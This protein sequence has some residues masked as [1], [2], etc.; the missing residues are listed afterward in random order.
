MKKV[1]V[2]LLV[3]FFI[4]LIFGA[5]FYVKSE[6][7]YVK[8]L[9]PSVDNISSPVN[10]VAFSIYGKDDVV[11]YR[12][13]YMRSEAIPA[14][15]GMKNLMDILDIYLSEMYSS[16]SRDGIERWK[17]FILNRQGINP[18]SLEG[19]AFSYYT[20][21]LIK[22][23][24]LRGFR[25]EL[26]RWYTIDKLNK[27]YSKQGLTRILLNSPSFAENVYG[28][29]A[30]CRYYF[31][32]SIKE[33]TLLERAY[34]T[35]MLSPAGKQLD[36][37]DD[38]QEIDRTARNIV[39]RL[40]ENNKISLEEMQASMQERV[41]IEIDN[42]KMIE[43]SYV[44]AVLRQLSK[45]NVVS[46][47]LGKEDIAVYTGYNKRASDTARLVMDDYLK[48][49]DSKLQS[50]FVL[51]NK[52][53]QEVEVALG[54]RL[55]DTPVNRALTM[56]RQMASTFKPIVYLGAFEK[57]FR[58]S[59]QIVDKQYSFATKDYMYLPRNYGGRFMGKIPIRYGFI[60]SLNNATVRLGELAG[61]KYIRD[62]SVRLG[63]NNNVKPFYAMTL[64]AF[65]ATP[66]TVA[67]I[68]AG[69]GNGGKRV[70]P[71]LISRIRVGKK[72]Y[73]MVKKQNRVVSESSAYQAL[74]IM[75][76]VTKSGTGRHIGLLPGTASKTGTSNEVRDAWTAAIFDKY[77]AAA[78]VGYDNMTPIGLSGSGGSIA[79]PIVAG[80]QRKYYPAGTV[81]TFNKP[82][83][84]V[85]KRVNKKT[86]YLTT[87]NNKDT[88]IEAYKKG[89]LP[90]VEQ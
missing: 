9:V 6:I 41:R 72:E 73:S 10:Q 1:Y 15:Y 89:N 54:S 8:L 78:W 81:F 44:H 65:P 87:K 17:L 71:M 16:A 88:Y 59:D 84:V 34:L 22:D 28:I 70:Y 47:N 37:I 35:A 32:K 62:L 60:Y 46:S 63:M 42:P 38:Y 2:L 64:G 11:M 26:L 13:Y 24:K 82:D 39:Y 4:Q 53:T 86:G 80:F 67:T 19:A 49:K 69:I 75:Q 3:V 36:I 68:Y 5:V 21:A 31:S 23:K 90:R 12:K 52:E 58:P 56:S 43:P 66:L 45:I 79:G 55:Y 74:Y 7:E 77:S 83:N 76:A 51:L 48:D 30:A 25:K 85:L 50:A 33:S 27:K 40:Y 29:S 61:I 57:G 14:D 20:D 18:F